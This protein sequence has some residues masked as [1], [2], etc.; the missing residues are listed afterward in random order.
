MGDFVKICDSLDPLNLFTE[1]PI[2][3]VWKEF[4]SVSGSIRVYFLELVD[5]DW[6]FFVVFCFYLINIDVVRKSYVHLILIRT[7]PACMLALKLWPWR[8]D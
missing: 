8:T 6:Y 1:S 3:D 5:F 7:F 4:K 2:L